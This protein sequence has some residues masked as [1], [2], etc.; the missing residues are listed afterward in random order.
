MRSPRLLLALMIGVIMGALDNSI[1]A[2][3][4]PAVGASFH[5]DPAQVVLAFSI[6]SVFYAVSV[7]LL[8]KLSD[9]LGYKLIYGA[10]MGLFA[11]G[12][13]LSALSPSLGFLVIARVIQAIGA[14]GLFP[15]AQA[16]IG[17]VY[18]KEERGRALG[19]VLGVFALGNVVG[20]NLGGFIVQHASWH[21]CFWINV[22]IGALG[23]LLL[24]GLSLPRPSRHPRI[25][26]VGA[27]L[28]ALGFGSL[29]LGIQGLQDLSHVGFWSLEIVGRFGLAALGLLLL[30]G[31]ERGQTEP[32]VDVRLAL[33]PAFAPLL[34]VSILVGYALLGG[35][36]FSPLFSQLAYGLSA[37]ASG[38]ILNSLALSLAITSG[39]GG[40]LVNRLGGKVLVIL[41]MALSSSGLLLMTY[42]SGPLWGLLLG[43][44]LLGLGLGFVQG[45]LSFLALDLAPRGS[46]GQVSSLVSLTRSL[47]AAA[48]ITLSGVFLAQAS[49]KLAAGAGTFAQQAAGGSNLQSLKHAPPFVQHLVTQTLMEGIG[50][51]WK[52]AGLAALGGLLFALLLVERRGHRPEEIP[53]SEG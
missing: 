8:G 43:L 16:I 14:G 33:S 38:A 32:I 18:P 37:F 40:A 27:G 26:W 44:A 47:G 52:I 10:S 13:M 25:D 31:W 17:A 1:L 49:Q 41:G 30:W 34:L 19:A 20:P 42:A 23:V 53:M 3:A 7:P 21:W 11:L 50:E 5:V 46:Q 45:P 29:V 4:L 36:I 15:V 9:L 2:P 28:V 35:I 24:S 48:G 51:G 6:Y 12:S 22:P 39:L